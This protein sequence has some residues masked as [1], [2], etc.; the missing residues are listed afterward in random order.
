MVL[1][2]ETR[3]LVGAFSTPQSTTVCGE[4][5]HN[6]SQSPI[7]CI[8]LQL[9]KVIHVVLETSVLSDSNYLNCTVCTYATHGRCINSWANVQTLYCILFM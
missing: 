6:V 7:K 3:P 9:Q 5:I 2:S 4:S 8:S 1:G